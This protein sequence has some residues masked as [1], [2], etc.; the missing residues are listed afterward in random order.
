MRDAASTIPARI[1]ADES[2]LPQ[3]ILGFST[4]TQRLLVPNAIATLVFRLI[5]RSIGAGNQVRK[6][7]IELGYYARDPHA[8]RDP[9]TT[10]RARMRQI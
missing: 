1:E 8:E 5:E 3:F 9:L 2:G 6:V 7:K 10:S 4:R